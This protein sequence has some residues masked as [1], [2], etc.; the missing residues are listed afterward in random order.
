MPED[1]R[2]EDMGTRRHQKIRI[3]MLNLVVKPI[4]QAFGDMGRTVFVKTDRHGS[5]IGERR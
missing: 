3:I 1:K 5:A 2:L 4:R